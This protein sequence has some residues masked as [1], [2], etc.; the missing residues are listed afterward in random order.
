MTGHTK[1]ASDAEM[2]DA[3]FLLAGIDVLR[4]YE[5]PN[6]YWPE[7]YTG[8]RK[9]HPWR[10]MVT[11]IGEVVVGWR[12]RVISIDWSATSVRAIVTDDNVTKSDTHVH[13]YGYVDAL[14]Y[15]HALGLAAARGEQ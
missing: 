3:L 2:F 10:L 8:M 7:A 15:L 1:G 6:G 13:A 5:I 4:K 14:R 12:K 9:R 11:P